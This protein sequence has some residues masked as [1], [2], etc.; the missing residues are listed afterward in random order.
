[1][2]RTFDLIADDPSAVPKMSSEMGAMRIEQMCD[3]IV[4]A[5]KHEVTCKPLHRHDAPPA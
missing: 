5:V 1:M 4:T 2:K 3:T